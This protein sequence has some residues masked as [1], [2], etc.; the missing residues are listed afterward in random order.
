[1]YQKV[2]TKLVKPIVNATFPD[3]R[4]RS[5]II[6]QADSITFYGVNWSGGSRSEYQACTVN[7]K[8]LDR[9]IDMG[10]A[11]PW[12]NPYEGLTVKIPPGMVVVEGGVFCGKNAT[13]NITFN[14]S[15]TP[16]LT[17]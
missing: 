7:G 9:M 6:R 16:L 11:A 13:L 5:V 2:A 10:V 12:D 4:K 8:P 14:P 17:D 15:D 1:M 3:Y